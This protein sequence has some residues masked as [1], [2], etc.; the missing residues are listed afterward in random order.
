[1]LTRFEKL[2]K[3]YIEAKV[4]HEAKTKELVSMLNE[5]FKTIGIK[6]NKESDLESILTYLKKD[7]APDGEDKLTTS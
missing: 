3:E 5:K 7:N 6:I 2:Y 1:M 4:E